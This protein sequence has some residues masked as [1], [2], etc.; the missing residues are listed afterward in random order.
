[1]GNEVAKELA[2]SGNALV[3][4]P[5]GCGK[6]YTIAESVQYCDGR[7]LILTHTH[8]GVRA[9]INH[10]KNQSVPTKK[11][12][13]TT[14]HSFALKYACAFPTLSG[15]TQS[16]PSSD[17]WN[18]I[19]SA[20]CK[21]LEKK[22]VKKILT[23]SYNGVYVD[24]YQ[25]CSSDQHEIVTLLADYLPCRIV[26]DPL[27]AIFGEVNKEKSLDWSVVLERFDIIAE[28]DTPWRWKNDNIELGDWLSTV[29]KSMLNGDS[30]DFRT[31]P[32][33]LVQDTGQPT[34][35]AEC[36]NAIGDKKESTAAIRKWGNQCHS[37]ARSLNNAFCS[38][39]TVEC[40]DL[41]NWAQKFEDTRGPER[42]IA[43][44]DFTKKCISRLPQF[45]NTLKE[46][47]SSDK[48]YNP[49]RADIKKVVE[50]FTEIIASDEINSILLAMT[51]IDDL[52]E[53]L[54]Y[55]RRELWKE[56][57][58]TLKTYITKGDGHLSDIAWNIRDTGRKVGRKVDKKTISTTLLI[59]GLEFDHAVILNANELDDAE[60]LYVAM[61]RGSKSLTV[62]SENPAI[63]VDLPRYMKQAKELE[64]GSDHGERLAIKDKCQ[65]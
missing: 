23:N 34:Q 38:M 14:I 27:Q 49:Q 57:K 2:N 59:K 64:L 65:K 11:Y 17:E 1:M 55:A 35:I 9:I 47:I 33:K 18:Q 25:D 63:K 45:I 29:R 16:Q 22:A 61:T 12:R 54:V 3:V 56:M 39:E 43:L 48:K 37:L 4:A 26:G 21:S 24:E 5:A 50:A 20:S 51:A 62:L 15:W 6:T 40:E 36:Y 60:N 58:K 13:V 31:G 19:C 42:A 7:Q 53:S 41:I 32:I 52:N 44:V 30:V 8:A 28:L 10:L 46:R